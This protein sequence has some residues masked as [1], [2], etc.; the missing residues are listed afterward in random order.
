[1]S[2]ATARPRFGAIFGFSLRRIWW[3]AWLLPWVIVLTLV[4]AHVSGII[5]VPKAP[6]EIAAPIILSL[7]LA[8]SLWRLKQEKTPWML[9]LSLLLFAFLCRE[10]HFA[11]TSAAVYPAVFTLFFIAWYRYPVYA[12]YLGSRQVLTLFTTALFCYFTAVGLDGHWW[13][14]LPGDKYD[15]A[16]VEEYVEVTGHLL[17]LALVLRSRPVDDPLTA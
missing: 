10:F 1:M 17:L 16:N 7:A 11:G 9:W 2:Q 13:K 8:L 15:W 3:P 14:F 12:S 5:T 4:P 6:G